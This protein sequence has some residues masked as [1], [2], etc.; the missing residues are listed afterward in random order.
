M[1]QFLINKKILKCI[2]HK[3]HLIINK[4]PLNLRIILQKDLYKIQDH[5][6]KEN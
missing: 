3:L 1:N 4:I 6:L 5:N 2:N